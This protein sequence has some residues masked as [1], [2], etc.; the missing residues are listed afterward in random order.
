MEGGS[1]YDREEKVKQEK[2]VHDNHKAENIQS[3]KIT[4]TR[5]TG[6]RCEDGE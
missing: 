6:K 1:L 3:M 5:I 2:T 4:K